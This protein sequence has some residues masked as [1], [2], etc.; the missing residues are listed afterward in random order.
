MSLEA[1]VN[2]I[3]LRWMKGRVKKGNW[4]VQE[5]LHISLAQAYGHEEHSILTYVPWRGP[6]LVSAHRGHLAVDSP[7]LENGGRKAREEP[8][9]R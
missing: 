8:E 3:S 2:N 5:A 7:F 9:P 4:H 6:A 1:P